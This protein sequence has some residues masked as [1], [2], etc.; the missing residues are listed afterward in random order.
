MPRLGAAVFIHVLANASLF[1][2]VAGALDCYMQ[3]LGVP[4]SEVREHGIAPRPRHD[5]VAREPT[6]APDEP[7]KRK[8]R[9]RRRKSQA[10]ITEAEPPSS[11][12]SLPDALPSVSLVK[13]QPAHLQLRQ[14]VFGRVQSAPSFG[15]LPRTALKAAPGLA[16]GALREIDSAK[17]AASRTA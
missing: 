9:S 8:R 17:D 15:E 10:K 4:I 1:V 11:I 3:Q 7:A 16:N 6:P 5:E 12:A 14:R 2:P 13:A